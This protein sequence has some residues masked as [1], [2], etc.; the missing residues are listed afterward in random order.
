M[1]SL[2]LLIPLA[3]A[4]IMGAVA[5]FVWAAISGQFD[6]LDNPEDHMP[7]NEPWPAAPDP[8]R[9]DD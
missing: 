7:D 5:V 2:Y 1:A 3:L 8:S 4:T 9:R 6:E